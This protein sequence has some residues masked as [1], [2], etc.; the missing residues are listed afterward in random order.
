V[1]GAEKSRYAHESESSTVRGKTDGIFR[2]D[3]EMGLK[4]AEG[5]SSSSAAALIIALLISGRAELSPSTSQAAET[6]PGTVEYTNKE[7]GFSFSL[8]ESW[9]GYKVLWSEWQGNVLAPS[10]EMTHVLHGPKLQIRH[11]NWT[12]GHPYEDM[13][14][15]IFTT[16]QWNEAPVVSAAPFGPTELGR[17][18]KYVFAVP[19]RWDYDFSEGYE[20]AEKI[21]I[22]SSL[23]AI[24]PGK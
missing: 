11:P 5:L 24:A 2:R 17:N 20:E 15:L 9:K 18:R 8:P 1:V 3:D 22:P 10:G 19:P 16:A 7:Y 13:P 12:Q 14:I 6:K 23:H 21:L 4:Q